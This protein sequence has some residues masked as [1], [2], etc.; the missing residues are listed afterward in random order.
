[1]TTSRTIKNPIAYPLFI[2][3]LYQSVLLDGGAVR[4]QGTIILQK[5]ADGKLPPDPVMVWREGDCV[6]RSS[7]SLALAMIVVWVVSGAGAVGWL[8]VTRAGC[9]L[10]EILFDSWLETWYTEEG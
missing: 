7:L 5:G 6:L 9:L 1:M 4:G 8:A 3:R 10:V 2:R